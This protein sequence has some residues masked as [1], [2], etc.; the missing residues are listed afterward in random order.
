[1]RKCVNG[2]YEGRV[3]HSMDCWKRTKK[4]L[5]NGK[6][7]DALQTSHSPTQ[8]HTRVRAH[9]HA[10]KHSVS[11]ANLSKQQREGSQGCICMT[12]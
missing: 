9:T 8:T 6:K 4:I 7:S 1:M 11:P 12:N 2:T 5:E 10:H 3:A